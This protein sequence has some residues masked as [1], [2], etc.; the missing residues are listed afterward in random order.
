MS[1]RAC[2]PAGVSLEPSAFVMRDGVSEPVVGLFRLMTSSRVSESVSDSSCFRLAPFKD[3]REP[4]N[5]VE[6][7]E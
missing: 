1:S 6:P 5:R 3:G 7:L 2:R 4:P